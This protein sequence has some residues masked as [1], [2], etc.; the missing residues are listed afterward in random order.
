[1]SQKKENHGFTCEWCGARVLPVT[2][3]SYR[4]H[5]PQC[6]FSKHVDC[7]PGDRRNTCQGLM[8]PIDLI[9]KA[10]KGYQL[11]HECVRCGATRANKVAVDTIQPDDLIGWLRC[12]E[13]S[14]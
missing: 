7:E 5:C 12:N 1:M 10:K 8:K 14:R 2:N 4:N 3:G 6:L 13:R 9:Y 11:V